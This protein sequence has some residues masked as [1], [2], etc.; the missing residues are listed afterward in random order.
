MP[1]KAR[2]GLEVPTSAS[3]L[4]ARG[5]RVVGNLSVAPPGRSL[6]ATR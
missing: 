5:G 3:T 1:L 2:A 4:R 6:G